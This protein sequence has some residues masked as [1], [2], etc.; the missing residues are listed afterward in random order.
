MTR[1]FVARGHQV[2]LDG[3]LYRTA[4][5]A[6]RAAIA[7]GSKISEAAIVKRLARGQVTTM[8][9]LME[10]LQSNRADKALAANA[11][12]TQSAR[13]EVAEALAALAARKAEIAA[14]QR[15]T[16]EDDDDE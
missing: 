10:P 4:T 6:A 12:K 13:D 3:N 7:A 9:E 15:A 16:T 5:L 8:A 2:R 14:R 1:D 11:A